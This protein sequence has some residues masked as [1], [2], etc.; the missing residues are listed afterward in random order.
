[1]KRFLYLML[2]LLL[3]ANAMAQ[4]GI[5][6]TTVLDNVALQVD[7]SN[8]GILIPRLTTAQRDAIVIAADP[9][10]E[11]LIIYNLDQNCINYYSWELNEWQSVCGYSSR[12]IFTVDCN[13]IEVKG[14]YKNTIALDQSN[15]VDVTVVVTSPGIYDIGIRPVVDNGYYFALKGEFITTGTI[16]LRIPSFGIPSSPKD[17]SLEV[18]INGSLQV[19][20]CS[21]DIKVLNGSITS[22][23]AM[24]C[25]SIKINGLYELDKILDASNT[26]EFYVDVQPSAIGGVYEFTTNTKSGISFSGSGALTQSRQLIT[27]K[28]EGRPSTS[29]DIPL[30]LKSNSSSEA[31][32]CS[33]TVNVVKLKKK[34][35]LYGDS[36]KSNNITNTSSMGHLLLTSLVNFGMQ[37]SSTVK[38]E[39]WEI[40]YG[41]GNYDFS[42]NLAKNSNPPDIIFI[43]GNVPNSSAN[44]D[45]IIKYLFDGGVVIYMT[46]DTS[47]LIDLTSRL[48]SFSALTSAVNVSKDAM[49]YSFP[50]YDITAINGSF[51]N[52]KSKNWGS[53]YSL[54]KLL[55]TE[56]PD[57]YTF[58]TQIDESEFVVSFPEP[59]TPPENQEPSDG[60]SV[61]VPE[62][63]LPP[64][65][66]MY[67]NKQ[68]NL[69]WIG[70]EEFITRVDPNGYQPFLLDAQN[71]PI[72][73]SNY[74][75]NIKYSVYNSVFLANL[76]QWAIL[77]SENNGINK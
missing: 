35:L 48:T 51:G 2:S 4:T 24:D 5:N 30:E 15:Y 68:Y 37:P 50:S 44:L 1:M 14:N 49:V 75:H 7:S 74:G 56:L 26:I 63:T 27:L 54:T 9:I 38:F 47:F 77:E 76:L 42:N 52:L 12:A 31:K 28:G 43:H 69:F 29:L 62:S 41:N 10:N 72:A 66:S 32:T 73:Q 17:D 19:P 67:L 61:E 60:P 21:L 36:S 46:N 23:F 34:I 53:R 33:F 71:R 3:F 25:N 57:F 8:K 58:S 55:S 16:K 45:G 40:V 18:F 13:K 22:D 20:H 70:E 11:G 59:P 6:T 64:Y 39:G 65:A